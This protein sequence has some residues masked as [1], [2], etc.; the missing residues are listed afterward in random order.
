M[1]IQIPVP[2]VKKVEPVVEKKEVIVENNNQPEGKKEEKMD[3]LSQLKNIQL[4]K[5]DKK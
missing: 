3:F 1:N 2:K 5:T 4:K